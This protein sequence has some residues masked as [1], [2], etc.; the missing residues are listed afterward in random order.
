MALV[1]LPM[2]S[3]IQQLR[4]KVVRTE[5]KQKELEDKQKETQKSVDE[6]IE[7]TEKQA[8][9]ITTLREEKDLL[10]MLLKNHKHQG[11]ETPQLNLVYQIGEIPAISDTS[12]VTNAPIK[13]L[14]K[15]I[16]IYES[17]AT[18]RLYIYDFTN[19]AWK[20]V[21]LT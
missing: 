9:E 11:L 3:D 21:N 13:N 1:D 2:G 7:T 12:S 15:Q 16:K 8:E 17:G 14:S 5:R 10:E 4:T 19:K 20:Y 18:K 6:L